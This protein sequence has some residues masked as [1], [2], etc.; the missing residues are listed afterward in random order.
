[1][2]VALFAG[3]LTCFG[4][5]SCGERPGSEATVPTES[6]PQREPSRT[7]SGP[8]GTVRGVVRIAEGAE[9]PLYVPEQM[10]GS[11]S[12]AMPSDCTPPRVD[13]RR[14]VRAN[15]AGLLQN[16]VVTLTAEDRDGFFARMAEREPAR[17]D[18]VIRD[19]R[20]DPPVLAVARGDV[21]VLSNETDYP[22]LPASTTASRGFMRG[23]IKGEPQEMVIDQMGVTS[24][25]CAMLAG[26][27]RT[28]VV[29]SSHALNA[30][31]GEDGSFVIEDVP[32]GMALR[33]HAWHPL[34]EESV[35][36]VTVEEGGDAR[37]E[38]TIRPTTPPAAPTETEEEPSDFF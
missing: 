10:G 30:V 15:E 13:D 11:P 31:T 20:L 4:C 9:P 35:V 29:V 18:V 21:L 34:F 12:V 6:D 32:A 7:T 25:A 5:G 37:V 19:C 16:V 3:A 14:P 33:V 2:S 38:L 36:D 17:H 1:M 24:L 26:C 8:V 27:G 23:L 22:F 28:D